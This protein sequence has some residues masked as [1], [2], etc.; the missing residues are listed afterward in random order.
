MIVTTKIIK[1]M[2]K[3]FILII[4]TLK[5]Y[6]LELHDFTVMSN[7]FVD[8]TD[9]FNV[10]LQWKPD[11]TAI[12]YEI[13]INN[14]GSFTYFDK[15]PGTQNSYTFFDA[16]FFRGESKEIKIEKTFQLPDELAKGYGY[17]DI[18]Y[19]LPLPDSKGNILLCVD[20]TLFDS[21]KTEFLEYVKILNLHGFNAQYVKV[22]RADFYNTKHVL[23]TK[24]ITKTKY[25][26]LNGNLDYIILVGRVAVPY[27]GS[28]S[29]DGHADE[30]YGAWPSDH[31]YG[32]FDGIWTDYKIDTVRELQPFVKML[33]HH[34][35]SA[36]DG[37]FDQTIFPSDVETSVGRIDV[38]DLPYFKE[39]EVELLKRYF[40]KNINWRK[41]KVDYPRRTLLD[42]NFYFLNSE[43][44]ATEAWRNFSS[45]VGYQ[46]IDTLSG[47]WDLREKEYLFLWGAASGAYVGISEVAFSIEYAEIPFKGVFGFLFGS[48]IL[49]FMHP[50]N[51]LKAQ[52]ASEPSFLTSVWSVRPNWHL[53]GMAIGKS[54]GEVALNSINNGEKYDDFGFKPYT[55][56]V[57]MNII[58]DPSLQMLV[59]DPPENVKIK[60]NGHT[61]EITWDTQADA[62]Y[63]NVYFAENLM[64][65]KVRLNLEP[66]TLNQFSTQFENGVFFVKSV[67]LQET[68]T[69][70]FWQ[71][72]IGIIAE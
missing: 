21:I 44:F 41:G 20:N 71:E 60:K 66:I 62:E 65:E 72:S 55:G 31:F 33:H 36:W 19:G 16:E 32:E 64:S 4:F 17:L 2:Y 56:A 5:L 48:R 10:E 29:P 57:F 15:V 42:D 61:A 14:S 39:T 22:P 1:K 51:T 69:G 38:S 18:G 28:T 40:R 45:L 54:L 67:K 68:N 6:S 52:I 59:T 24:T 49:E 13:S 34:N 63:Y 50:N 58:G 43:L 8:S 25:E 7:V 12:E 37:K 53:Q 47:R 11:T 46:N 9:G 70:S 26:E 27:S 35:N 30:T 3:I 23:H